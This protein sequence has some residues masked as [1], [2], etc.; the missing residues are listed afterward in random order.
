[1]P[2]NNSDHDHHNTGLLSNSDGSPPANPASHDPET[3]SLSSGPIEGGFSGLRLSRGDI[4]AKRYTLSEVL[5]GGGFG[6]VWRATDELL[7]RDVAVKI[8]KADAKIDD[9]HLLHEART[10][11]GLALPGLVPVHDISRESEYWFVVS[12]L[13]TGGSL[14]ERMRRQT[15]SQRES[16][17]I[18][19]QLAETLQRLH[20]RNFVHRDI[21]PA[22]ILFDQFG[23]AFVCDLGLAIDE[24][25]V[26]KQHA[27]HYGTVKYMSPEQAAGRPDLVDARSDQFSLGVVLYEMLTRRLPFVEGE[28]KQYLQQIVERPARP[29]R[30]IDESISPALERICLTALEKNVSDRFTTISDFAVALRTW[31]AD[32]QGKDTPNQEK[33][34]TPKR[35]L[36]DA[37]FILR[38][39]W[40]WLGGIGLAL[41][42]LLAS[43]NLSL[44]GVATPQDPREGVPIIEPVVSSLAS[45]T[46]AD[47]PFQAIADR[48]LVAGRQYSLLRQPPQPLFGRKADGI[49]FDLERESLHIAAFN[50]NVLELAT[51]SRQ[52]YT[53]RI[54]VRQTAGWQGLAG[55]IWGLHPDPQD[56]TTL[57]GQILLLQRNTNKDAQD[58]GML[59]LR[60]QLRFGADEFELRAPSREVKFAEPIPSAPPGHSF[61]L[62]VRVARGR[63]TSI[64]CAGNQL[65]TLVTTELNSAFAGEFYQGGVGLLAAQVSGVT[66]E[67]ASLRIEE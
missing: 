48:D 17:E 51:T 12:E 46:G 3:V 67:N 52:H 59:A 23:Q 26:V 33:S 58:K 53:V 42:L 8:S 49:H 24:H 6:V 30:T 13:M 38:S 29:L 32:E 37:R 15:F 44:P 45:T 25:E 66:F 65:G 63:V 43:G 50:A 31:L 4:L 9:S 55:L 7:G 39:P 41:A 56:S 10:V 62:E 19:A 14:S 57:V 60:Q 40:L 47:T 27:G 36:S 34:L 35:V 20:L 16:V 11:A 64:R 61:E 2:H 21:K 28:A 18:V 22:N 5:G 1:M 54:D